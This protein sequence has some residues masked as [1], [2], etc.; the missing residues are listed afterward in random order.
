MQKQ[1]KRYM[2]NKREVQPLNGQESH[3]R[4]AAI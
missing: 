3:P 1:V 4:Q 2:N